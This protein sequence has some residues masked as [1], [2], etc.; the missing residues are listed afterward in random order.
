MSHRNV[1]ASC[2]VAA[3]LAL[4]PDAASAADPERGRLLYENH[5]RECHTST[6][7]VREKRKAASREA[8]EAWVRRW[9]EQLGLAWDDQEIDDV[10]EHLNERYYG[11]REES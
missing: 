11:F 3:S 6:V 4:L 10:V 1:L 5:C 9:R 2:V 8:I 7:H